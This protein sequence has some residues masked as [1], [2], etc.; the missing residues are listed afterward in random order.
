MKEKLN[1][2]DARHPSVGTVGINAQAARR[3]CVKSAVPLQWMEF[4]AEPIPNGA[5]AES[6]LPAMDAWPMRPFMNQISFIVKNVIYFNVLR[7][8]KSMITQ[9]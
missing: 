4:Y 7:V 5:A 1:V 8:M 6:T 9:K 3:L 2:S